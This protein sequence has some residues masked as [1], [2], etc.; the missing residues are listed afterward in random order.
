MFNNNKNVNVEI[1]RYKGE[2][3]SALPMV[4]KKQYEVDKKKYEHESNTY[5]PEI[6]KDLFPVYL[7]F[8]KKHLT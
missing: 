7:K 5:Y 4:N 8:F 6:Y 3:I 2:H 1:Y